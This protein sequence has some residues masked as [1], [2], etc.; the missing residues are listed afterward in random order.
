MDKGKCVDVQDSFL[1]NLQKPFRLSSRF[2]WN[3]L[4]W[5]CNSAGAYG[6]YHVVHSGTYNVAVLPTVWLFLLGKCG[7]LEPNTTAGYYQHRKI[8]C[9]LCLQSV[10]W[11]QLKSISRQKFSWFFEKERHSTTLPLT[12]RYNAVVRLF[13]LTLEEVHLK[14]FPLSSVSN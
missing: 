4:R 1:Q 2:D 12:Q 3:N 9:A 13:S 10:M 6:N 11:S 8:A 5:V 14:D 7:C